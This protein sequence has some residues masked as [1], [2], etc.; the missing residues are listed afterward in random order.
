MGGTAL[1]KCRQQALQF[2]ELYKPM[3]L[4]GLIRYLL[5]E[6]EVLCE[7]R[8]DLGEILELVCLPSTW[9]SKVNEINLD[10]REVFER[11]RLS[12]STPLPF[13]YSW[14]PRACSPLIL[15]TTV[16]SILS[17]FSPRRAYHDFRWRKVRVPLL[18][19]GCMLCATYLLN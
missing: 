8:A 7:A 13:T 10:F 19:T 18:S 14:D 4:A 17:P 11:S 16:C 6:L 1:S 9:L 15:A 3:I 12:K 2:C 5:R